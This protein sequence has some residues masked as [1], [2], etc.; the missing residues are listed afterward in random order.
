MLTLQQTTVFGG[1]D[2]FA[3]NQLQVVR[4]TRQQEDVRQT[5][6]DTAVSRRIGGVIQGRLLCGVR[7]EEAGV[8]ARTAE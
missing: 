7:R 5:R 2:I 3:L 1:A 4:N 8:I 6:V